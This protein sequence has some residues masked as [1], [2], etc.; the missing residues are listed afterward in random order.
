MKTTP[1]LAAQLSSKLKP[2]PAK[3]RTDPRQKRR[4]VFET[5]LNLWAEVDAGK[6]GADRAFHQ[7]V[8][9]AKWALDPQY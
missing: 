4:V 1:S 9:A 5:I 8:G 7:I 3:H 6:I 2:S